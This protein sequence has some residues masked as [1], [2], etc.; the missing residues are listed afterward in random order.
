METMPPKRT[1]IARK[2]ARTKGR[3]NCQEGNNLSRGEMDE[4]RLQ[5]RGS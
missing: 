4:R 5:Y 3:R 1:G 2:P